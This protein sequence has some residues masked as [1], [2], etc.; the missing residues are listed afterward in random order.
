MHKA[1]SLGNH[2]NVL[3]SSVTSLIYPLIPMGKLHS[4]LCVSPSVIFL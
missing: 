4:N 2:K 3:L 1:I